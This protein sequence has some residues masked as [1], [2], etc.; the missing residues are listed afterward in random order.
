MQLKIFNVNNYGSL[1]KITNLKL[2]DLNKETLSINGKKYK[3]ISAIF[4]HGNS[5]SSG[6]YTCILRRNDHCL[7]INDSQ[8]TRTFWPENSQNI[9]LIFL[10][11][12]CLQKLHHYQQ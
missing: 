4:H 5:I 2:K 3:V 6:H 10:D 7:R 12:I 11:E 1:I 8:V 9:Y